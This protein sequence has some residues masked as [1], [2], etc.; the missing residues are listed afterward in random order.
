MSSVRAALDAALEGKVSTEGCLLRWRSVCLI[1]G[2][3]S[4]PWTTKRTAQESG[5]LHL[6]AHHTKEQQQ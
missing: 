5:L 1:C 3:D 4:G 2:L 6:Y